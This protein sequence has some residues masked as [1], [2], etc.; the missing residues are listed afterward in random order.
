MLTVW[1][2]A[3]QLGAQYRARVGVRG[4]GGVVVVWVV[5]VCC[6]RVYGGAGHGMGETF[7]QTT[8]STQERAMDEQKR[9]PSKSILY[10][11]CY[12]TQYSSVDMLALEVVEDFGQVAVSLNIA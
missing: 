9:G 4:G 10:N 5:V 11:G 1:G 8:T 7:G 2:N 3:S 6:L 12:I